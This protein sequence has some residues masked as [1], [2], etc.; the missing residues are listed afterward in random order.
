MLKTPLSCAVVG[1]GISALP[2]VL[3]L[4]HSSDQKK[5]VLSLTGL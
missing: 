1:T 3:A 4:R 2:G 5:K